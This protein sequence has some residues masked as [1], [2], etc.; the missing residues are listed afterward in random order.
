[1]TGHINFK[2]WSITFWLI[3]LKAF[4]AY[5]GKIPSVLR[6]LKTSCIACIAASDPATYPPHSCSDPATW[7]TSFFNR[8]I[9]AFPAILLSTSPTPIGLSPGHLFNEINLHAMNDSRDSAFFTSSKQGLL[10][11]SVNVLR[12]SMMLFQINVM[13][14]FFSNHERQGQMVLIHLLLALLFSKWGT[15]PYLHTLLSGQVVQVPA[16]ILL[17]VVHYLLF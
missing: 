6:S 2:L 12:K 3:E 13:L 16:K 8:I 17:G 10:T 4:S 14:G 11:N 9:I 15:H 7:S 5:I 1:M